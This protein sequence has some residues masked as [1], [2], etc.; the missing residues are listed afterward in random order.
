MRDL[1]WKGRWCGKGKGERMDACEVDRHVGWA[2]LGWGWEDAGVGV[3]GGREG[4][5]WSMKT[6]DEFFPR[7][8]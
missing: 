8:R 1:G 2:G 3:L 6:R 4:G 7:W 5:V